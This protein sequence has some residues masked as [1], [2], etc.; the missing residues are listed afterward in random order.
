M[1]PFICADV[2]NSNFDKGFSSYS[3]YEERVV[4][5]KKDVE[6]FAYCLTDVVDI[7]SNNFVNSFANEYFET[8]I[9]FDNRQS[10][11]IGIS[12]SIFENSRFLDKNEEEALN[13]AFFN[14][15]IKKPTLK[16]RK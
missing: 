10:F 15:L 8:Q 4:P 3:F 6:L 1:I 5:V 7:E 2:S 16:G 13:L 11:L 9:F 12:N 14:S